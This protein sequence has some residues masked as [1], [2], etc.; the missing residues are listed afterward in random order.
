MQL[1][2]Q[3]PS[4]EPCFLFLNEPA[5]ALVVFVCMFLTVSCKIFPNSSFTVW[6]GFDDVTAYLIGK[7][8]VRMPQ[9]LYSHCQ[10]A[11]CDQLDQRSAEETTGR[12]AHHVGSLKKRV[13]VLKLLDNQSIQPQRRQYTHGWFSVIVSGSRVRMWCEFW[14][15]YPHD[16]SITVL[17]WKWGAGVKTPTQQITLGALLNAECENQ[18][19]ARVCP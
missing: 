2:W 9:T 19:C 17:Y 12:T 5:S 6:N 13:E 18:H 8:C 16:P 3:Q 7:A 14:W 10:H 11:V 4:K 15:S 1:L